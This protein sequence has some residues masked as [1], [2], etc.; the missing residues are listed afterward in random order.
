[1]NI[2]IFEYPKVL[3][4]P[5]ILR[6]RRIFVQT[7]N[8]SPNTI[9]IR[10][11]LATRFTV[12]YASCGLVAACRVEPL[13]NGCSQYTGRSPLPL[14]V[15][16]QGLTIADRVAESQQLQRVNSCR[17]LVLAGWQHSLVCRAS[18]MTLIG[19]CVRGSQQHPS[20]HQIH[21][22]YI[23]IYIFFFFLVLCLPRQ[24]RRSNGAIHHDPQLSPSTCCNPLSVS[25]PVTS[26]LVF[27][28]SFSLPFFP[29]L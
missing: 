6:R 16:N 15:W 20:N 1:M 7:K 3:T 23:Y 9:K 27:L 13:V 10:W 2:R 11:L 22:R 28:F 8:L 19:V 12:P 14:S 4:Y 29:R 26:F 18:G 5:I 25:S 17:G 24:V 21:H